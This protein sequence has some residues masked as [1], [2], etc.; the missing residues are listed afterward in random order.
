[1]GRGS[2]LSIGLQIRFLEQDWLHYEYS[3]IIK[4]GDQPMA[5]NFE[6]DKIQIIPPRRIFKNTSCLKA[7]DTV[8]V[9]L[10]TAIVLPVLI[11]R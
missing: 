1:M 9:P 3:R 2:G 5:A 4:D 11:E 6:S 8:S 10:M 7:L